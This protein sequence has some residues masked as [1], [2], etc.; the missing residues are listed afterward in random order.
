MA[1]TGYEIFALFMRYVF[2]L[3]GALILLRGLFWL[4]KDARAWHKEIKNLPDAG[5]VGELRDMQ[6]DQSYPLPREGVL[7]KKHSCDIRIKGHL[8]PGKALTFLFVE[9]KGLA[10]TPIGGQNVYLDGEAVRGSKG[11]ALHGTQ[12]EVGGT[13]MRVRL[14]AGLN[15][16]KRVLFRPGEDENEAAFDGPSPFEE[17]AGMFAPAENGWMRMPGQLAQNPFM[18]ET[19]EDETSSGISYAPVYA[20]YAENVYAAP[21]YGTQRDQAYAPRNVYD[22]FGGNVQQ[23]VPVNEDNLPLNDDEDVNPFA[24]AAGFVPDRMQPMYPQQNDAE[25]PAEVPARRRRSD[26]YL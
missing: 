11:Y 4:R 21:E 20:P 9:G 16:P 23:N 10:V 24:E 6:S 26:R 19:V 22:T 7:G 14:F 13:V 5:L 25:M 18:D 8:M 17:V 12:L 3:L 2:V 15:V 1:G